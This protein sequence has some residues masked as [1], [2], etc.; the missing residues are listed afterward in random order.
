MEI[1]F[2]FNG[3]I[4]DCPNVGKLKVFA[5]PFLFFILLVKN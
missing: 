3:K 1:I 2:S 5:R 4:N